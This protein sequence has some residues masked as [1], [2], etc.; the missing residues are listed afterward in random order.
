MR[1]FLFG[2]VFVFSSSLFSQTG[3]PA[4]D[5]EFQL[6]QFLQEKLFKSATAP[7]K[8]YPAEDTKH[9][10]GEQHYVVSCGNNNIE[11]IVAKIPKTAFFRGFIAVNNKNVLDLGST[12]QTKLVAEFIRL[13][14]SYCGSIHV[15]DAQIRK[16]DANRTADQ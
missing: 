5:K 1:T 11:I 2:V 7:K 8:V 10:G 3:D 4:V 14:K 12:S 6:K 16:Q 13:A 9:L 15:V